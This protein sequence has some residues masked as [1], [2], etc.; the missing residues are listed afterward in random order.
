M[1]KRDALR[2]RFRAAIREYLRGQAKQHPQFYEEAD[3][4]WTCDE[5]AMLDALM[6]AARS[7]P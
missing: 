3:P 2:E 7:K 6:K 4:E 1:K 5:E